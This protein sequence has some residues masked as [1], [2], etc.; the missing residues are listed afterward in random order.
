MDQDQGIMLR[1]VIFRGKGGALVAQALE[2]NIAAQGPDEGT[3]KENFE[4]ALMAEIQF[5]KE[6]GKEAFVRLPAAPARY[7]KLWD[8]AAIKEP[9]GDSLPGIPAWLASKLQLSLQ[10]RLAF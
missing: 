6:Q 4:K 3:L 8:E 10:P 2:H 1:I 7:W 5:S 9:K